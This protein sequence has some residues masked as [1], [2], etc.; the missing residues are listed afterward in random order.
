MSLV[1]PL[2]LALSAR[3]C[4]GSVVLADSVLCGLSVEAVFGQRSNPDVRKKLNSFGIDLEG[5]SCLWVAPVQRCFF[6]GIPKK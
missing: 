5:C 3:L 2:K 1:P 6:F 4:Q